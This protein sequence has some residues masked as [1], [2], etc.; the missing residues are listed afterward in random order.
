MLSSNCTTTSVLR[1]ISLALNQPST[2]KHHILLYWSFILWEFTLAHRSKNQYSPSQAQWVDRKWLFLAVSF[3]LTL[4]RRNKFC[5]HRF[6][7]L[8][9]F[10][11]DFSGF[12]LSK[13]E[14]RLNH[15]TNQPGTETKIERRERERSLVPE[16]K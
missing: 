15:L 12:N 2:S 5:S 1:P 7:W 9:T 11:A 13:T 3:S 6:S 16:A 4:E 10:S 8:L 14:T